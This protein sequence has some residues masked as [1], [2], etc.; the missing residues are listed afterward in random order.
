MKPTPCPNTPVLPTGWTISRPLIAWAN[1]LDMYWLPRSE[2]SRIRLNSDY[3]E[4]GVKPRNCCF[5]C[6]GWVRWLIFRVND[7]WLSEAVEGLEFVVG[8]PFCGGCVD[9]GVGCVEG[10]SHHVHGREGVER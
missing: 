9:G 3:A 10:V 4:V 1:S 2:L 8:E 7:W 6:V 5:V